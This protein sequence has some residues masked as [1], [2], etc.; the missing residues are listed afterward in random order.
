MGTT[1]YQYKVAE[2]LRA[3]A[4]RGVVTKPNP[5][6]LAGIYGRIASSLNE[7]NQSIDGEALRYG[8]NVADWNAAISAMTS[9]T[10]SISLPF[11]HR[12]ELLLDYGARIPDGIAGLMDADLD[13]NGLLN[14]GDIDNFNQ[15]LLAG[16][17]PAPT[18]D[19]NGNGIVNSED[20]IELV[21]FYIGTFFGDSNLDGIFNSSD[22]VQVY[23][24]GEYDDGTNQNS[25]WVEGDWDGDLDF[26]TGD[27]TF[28]FNFGG[29]DPS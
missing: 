17:P 15:A 5:L 14:A 8:K 4:M 29:Y 13:N 21:W 27:L 18:Y 1:T 19:I 7:V 3:H 20:R 26:T 24:S 11:Q 23:Q 9:P 28:A 12:G 6:S 10:S 25:T 2:R 16:N 22:F